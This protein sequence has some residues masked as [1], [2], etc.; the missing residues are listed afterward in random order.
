MAMRR[1]GIFSP[2]INGLLVILAV[3]VMG[4]IF[5]GQIKSMVKTILGSAD[6]GTEDLI[7]VPQEEFQQQL[8]AVYN[9][10]GIGS[11][12][13]YCKCTVPMN[14]G[15]KKVYLRGQ[16][17]GRTLMSFFFSD[18]PEVSREGNLDVDHASSP[19][20]FGPLCL[21]FKEGGILGDPFLPPMPELEQFGILFYRE[22]QKLTWAANAGDHEGSWSAE[23]AIFFR[24]GDQQRCLWLPRVVDPLFG[25]AA[26]VNEVPECD[27]SVAAVD[28]A[29]AQEEF[30][31]FKQMVDN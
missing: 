8:T 21:H 27:A 18:D 31:R 11:T 20:H 6:E 17:E 2:L 19:A 15:E 9:N 24:A 10:C 5:S 12:Q 13:Q 22:G 26:L 25:E 1:G 23:P 3:V 28:I 7:E 30:I 14:I 4:A 29:A 16:G